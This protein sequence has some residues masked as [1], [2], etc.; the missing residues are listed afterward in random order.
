MIGVRVAASSVTRFRAPFRAPRGG[1]TERAGLFLAL[2]DGEG[3]VG[4]GEASPLPGYSP[5]DLASCERALRGV[6]HR[7]GPVVDDRAPSAIARA[8]E[9]LELR[10]LPAARFALE[11]ALLDLWSQRRGE[12]L[13]ESLGGPRPY[14]SVPVNGLL[15]ASDDAIDLERRARSLLERGLRVLKI[16][17]CAQDDVAFARELAALEALRRALPPSIELRFDPNAAYA[18]GEARDRLRALAPLRPAFVEQPVPAQD[19]ERLGPC[20][21]PW[22]ADESLMDPTTAARLLEASACSA[23]ILKPA[24][25]GLLGA[26]DLAARAQARGLSVV[27]THLFDG[28][29][30]H[31]AACELALALPRPPL[32]CGLDREGDLG[33]PP[34]LSIPH[35]AAPGLVTATGRPGLG[36]SLPSPPPWTA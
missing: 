32:A 22:A 35:L 13:A 6:H 10:A 9:P 17:L 11:T 23:F 14:T 27:V 4:H 20:A 29:I 15:V 2:D 5:D 8:I 1:L 19:L 26:Y 36:L 34:S 28:P 3:R 12:P 31:A 21:A 30:A 7:L 16:K 24:V 25:L 33:L 18:L